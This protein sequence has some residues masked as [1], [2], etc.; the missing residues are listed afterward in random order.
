[1]G[2]SVESATEDDCVQTGHSILSVSASC[3]TENHLADRCANHRLTSGTGI[4]QCQR[5]CAEKCGVAF[6]SPPSL[7]GSGGI[8]YHALSRAEGESVMIGV[9][10]R[11]GLLAACCEGG[12]RD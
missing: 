7:L 6:S 1:M 9:R 12:K 2:S 8:Q 11:S 4:C 10:I 5:R 3:K